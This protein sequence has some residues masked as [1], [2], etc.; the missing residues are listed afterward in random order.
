MLHF[1]L[2]GEKLG[3][4]L[5]VPIH[6]E[7]YR[8][9]GLDADYQLIEIP[10]EGFEAQV[11]QLLRELDGMNVTIPYKQRIMPLLEQ[12]DPRAARI[13][14][15]NTVTTRGVLCGHNTDA[16]GLR[17]LMEHHGILP[18][19]LRCCILGTGGSSHTARVV[20]EEMGA[21]SVTLVSRHP[22]EDAISYE[23]L[24]REGCAEFIV[25][26][27]PAGMW[28]NVDGCP[29]TEEQLGAV[30]PRVKGVVDIIYN[31][32]ETRLTAA[33]KHRGIPACTG[34]YM[35]VHQAVEAEKLWLNMD[36]S[37]DITGRIA[38]TIHL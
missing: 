21:A 19:G 2:I 11:P 35:L 16:A 31:P 3:H 34:L 30:L 25:N 5:S 26:T 38:E 22:S 29:L 27:T 4:S 8:L 1:A 9:L 12:I 32:P 18:R 33:A 20:L 23:Q 36:I 28:P 10:K 24:A 6:R 37:A 14:A 7:L 13:G 17:A 15:V